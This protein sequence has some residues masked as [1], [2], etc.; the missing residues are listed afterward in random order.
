MKKKF[1]DRSGAELLLIVAD[2][3]LTGFDAPPATYL[4]IDK[5]MRTTA[6]SGHLPRQPAGRRRQRAGTIVDHKTCFPV[7]RGF[8][9]YTGGVRRI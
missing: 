1:I 2:K 8:D 7:W 5:K 9:Q 4:Y 3:L 6:C